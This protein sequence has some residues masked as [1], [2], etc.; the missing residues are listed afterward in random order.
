MKKKTLFLLSGGIALMH[1]YAQDKLADANNEFAF[2]IYKAAKPD[3]ANFII[4]PFS[5]HIALS[6]PNEGARSTTRAE[7][8]SLLCIRNLSQR[9]DL[10]SALIKRTTMLKD[11]G[12]YKCP[13]W[14]DNKS[15]EG[16][17]LYLANSLWINN[18]LIIN[19]TFRQTIGEKYHS[20]FR[21]FDRSNIIT[22]N[23]ELNKWV[24]GKTNNKIKEIS[25]LNPDIKLSI[26]NAIYF[27]G[28]WDSPFE[29]K[30][31]RA[32]IFRTIDKNKV[33]IDFMNKRAWYR[34]YE[35]DDIQ[36]VTLDYKCDQFSMIVLLPH[37]R[38]GIN[39]IEP[40]LNHDYLSRIIG[41]RGGSEVILSLPK[42]KIETELLPKPAM[43][44]MG[45][46]EMFS[47]KAD[48]TGISGD[49][50]KIDEIIHKTFIELDEK[51]TEA[52]AVSKVDMVITGYGGG[53]PPP[54]P[55]PKVFNANHPFVFLIV[56]NRTGVII[57]IGRFVK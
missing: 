11:S 46:T 27:M 18:D 5:L 49:P 24:S 8:D 56:D 29:K 53:E 51:R 40:R 34:Y 31:T 22:A 17:E 25:G 30:K 43:L 52:A 19:D 32:K 2:T 13:E 41:S 36:A 48:F 45:Y 9:N 44:R 12:F 57:F 47:D 37:D 38:Y 10:Y 54:P 20:E 14:S 50:L 16:N 15:A 4:S 21:S 33:R 42:F 55:V 7:M 23:Q 6:A 26:I 1:A 35:D 39:Q 3:T 28:E